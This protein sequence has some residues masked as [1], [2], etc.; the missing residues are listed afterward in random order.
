[1]LN[2]LRVIDSSLARLP[3]AAVLLFVRIAVGHVFWSSGRSKMDGWFTMRPE[4][5]DLFRDEYQLPLI[6]PEIAA[7]MAATGEH[8]LPILLVL[9]LFT[10]FRRWGWLG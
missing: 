3:E 10:T 1:M 2:M 4:T 9:G 6:P 8:I 5:I 7:P